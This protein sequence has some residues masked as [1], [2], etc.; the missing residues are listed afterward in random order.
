MLVFLDAMVPEDGETTVDVLP[1]TKQLIDLTVDG[2]RVPPM[3][4]QPPTLGLSGGPSQQA[5]GCANC[6]PVT[7]A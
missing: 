7:T 5:N 6:R 1:V 3:P 2:W 4:E